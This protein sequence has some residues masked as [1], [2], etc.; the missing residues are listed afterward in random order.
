MPHRKNMSVF[1]LHFILCNINS[2]LNDFQTRLRFKN[3]IMDFWDREV[4]LL[5]LMTLKLTLAPLF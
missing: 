3:T 5:H 2:Q 1:P 4:T